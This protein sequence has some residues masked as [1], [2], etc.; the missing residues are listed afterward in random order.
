ML[1]QAVIFGLLIILLGYV[2]GFLAR[3]ITVIPP[4]PHECKNWNQNNTME[5]SLFITGF[6]SYLLLKYYE[7]N[8]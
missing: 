1:L 8:L 4:I 5:W 2:G 3:F 7:N 6:I